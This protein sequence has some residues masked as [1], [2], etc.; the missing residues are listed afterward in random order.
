MW[1][2]R[3]LLA[4]ERKRDL[5]AR[6]KVPSKGVPMLKALK[7]LSLGM[8]N[9]EGPRARGWNDGRREWEDRRSTR[10]YENVCEGKSVRG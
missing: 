1:K 2:E 10:V 4:F 8:G 9:G 6:K 3:T 5:N 7:G